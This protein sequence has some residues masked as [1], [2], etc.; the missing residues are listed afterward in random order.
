M[1]NT[2]FFWETT[3]QT[4]QQIPFMKSLL[5]SLNHALQD[6]DSLPEADWATMRD[7]LKEMADATAARIENTEVDRD[8]VTGPELATEYWTEYDEAMSLQAAGD[9][10]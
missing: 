2:S 8:L 5:M 7:H 1:L 9:P 6:L 3:V 10:F 4:W